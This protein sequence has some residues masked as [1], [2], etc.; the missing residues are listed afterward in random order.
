M[1]KWTLMQKL[2]NYREALLQEG[3]CVD[4]F[5]E[6]TRFMNLD[7]NKQMSLK[8]VFTSLAPISLYY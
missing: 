5:L 7:K 8:S 4:I 2:D 6:K 1:D 3:V